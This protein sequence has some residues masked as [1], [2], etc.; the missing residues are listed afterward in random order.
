M[1]SSAFLSR[2]QAEAEYRNYLGCERVKDLTFNHID[3]RSG[4]HERAW[5]G[6][7]VGIGVSY[8]FLEP[9]ESTG[10][11]LTQTAIIDLLTALLSPVT[12]GARDEFNRRQGAMFDTTRDFVAAHF[13]L[14]SRDDWAYWKHLRY[15]AAR[16]D[17]LLP[18]LEQA[19]QHTMSV[20]VGSHRSITL[21]HAA[22]Q[23]VP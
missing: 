18:L 16:P 2:D 21:R 8:G 12:A 6:N 14:T 11:S 23:D 22:Q 9:L 17:G 7:C 4:R 13:V 3:M 20:W 19:R 15:D 10:L 1:Y 5:V